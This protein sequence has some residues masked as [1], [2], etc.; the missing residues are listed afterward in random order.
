MPAVAVA[1]EAE[2]ARAVATVSDRNYV[3]RVRM[4]SGTV[5]G[6]PF[7]TAAPPVE[8]DLRATAVRE[9]DDG[10]VILDQPVVREDGTAV[11]STLMSEEVLD[12]GVWRAWGVLA[13]LA[14]TLFVL[15]LV[16]ADRLARVDDPA[17]RASWR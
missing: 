14:L 10:R 2:V 6:R 7:R 8:P 3:V 9:L 13:A 1:D 4:P 15:S 11:I 17:G 5:V 12:A 16:V